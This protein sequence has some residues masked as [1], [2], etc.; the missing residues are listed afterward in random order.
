MFLFFVVF[1]III[2][3]FAGYITWRLFGRADLTYI[4]R[5]VIAA[6]IIATVFLTPLNIILRRSGFENLL[7]DAAAWVGY[8][9]LGFLSFIFTFLVIRDLLWAIVNFLKKIWNYLLESKE[10]VV[11]KVNQTDPIRRDLLIR[12]VNCAIWGSSFIFSTYGLVEAKRNPKVK[13]VE[14][15]IGD[16]P[17]S[18]EGLRIV[19]I[20]DIHAS[21]TIGRSFIEGIVKTVNRLNPDIIVLTGD[22]A[23][24]SVPQLSRDVAPLGELRSAVGNFFVTGN[25]EYYSGV[26]EWLEKVGELGFK[27]LMN[28]HVVVDRGNASILLAGVTDYRGGE[29]IST[30]KSDPKRA[31]AGAPETDIKILLAH[32]PKSIFDAQK[33]GFD[34]QISG[35]THGGQFFP[36]NFVIGLAQP[37]VSGLHNYKGTQIYVSKGTGYWGPPC[38]VGPESEITLIGLTRQER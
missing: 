11:L 33:A 13:D 35:H 18:L 28:D 15:Q 31:I 17:R 2:G 19:Q 23:D 10:I 34:L 32:Q 4:S 38:R 8:L 20:T 7:V 1:F 9:G 16:L 5:L 30:H 22:L 21:P 37:F 3:L 6:G 36:W 27:V 12:G 29:F 25:H 14:I 24:G 26:I